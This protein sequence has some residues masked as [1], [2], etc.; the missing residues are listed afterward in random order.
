MLPRDP[1]RDKAPTAA[2]RSRATTP[3]GQG[4]SPV[5]PNEANARCRGMCERQRRG[6][7]EAGK[8][9]QKELSPRGLQLPEERSVVMP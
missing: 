9:W 4:P 1:A 6:A 8:N 2:G 5:H 7:A 3:R